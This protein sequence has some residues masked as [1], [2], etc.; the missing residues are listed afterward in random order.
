MSALNIKKT[1]NDNEKFVSLLKEVKDKIVD[2]DEYGGET[3]FIDEDGI[4]IMQVRPTEDP[5]CVDVIFASENE[6]YRVNKSQVS[7]LK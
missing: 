5:E 6:T 2:Y 3:D 7:S 4:V 1:V